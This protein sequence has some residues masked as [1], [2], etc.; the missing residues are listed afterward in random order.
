MGVSP[1]NADAARTPK[2][3]FREI[4]AIST[5]LARNRLASFAGEQ[6]L[7]AGRRAASHPPP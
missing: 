7:A 3:R 5:S 1:V 6:S 2:R 4:Q